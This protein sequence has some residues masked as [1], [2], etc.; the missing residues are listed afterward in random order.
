[1]A[2]S[3]WDTCAFNEKGEPTNG[4]VTKQLKDGTTSG[5]E[6]YKNWLYVKDTGMWKD[7]RS[8]SEPVIAEINEGRAIISGFR[9]Y[10]KRGPQ[11]SVLAFVEAGWKHSTDPELKYKCMAGIGCYGFDGEK[12]VGVQKATFDALVGWLDE[13][14]D[15]YVVDKDYLKLIRES[16]PLRMNQG[17]SFFADRFGEPELSVATKIG[18][19]KNPIILQVLK[20]E[21]EEEDHGNRK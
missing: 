21:K 7:G 3:N 12:W 20:T 18:E 5:V 9:I 10:A 1:M 14:V 16:D 17:D 11:R 2:L 19:P 15:D 8:F 6:I 13:L 4:A